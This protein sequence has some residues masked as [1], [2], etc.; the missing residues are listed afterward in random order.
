MAV[1]VYKA[2]DATEIVDDVGQE[3]FDLKSKGLV[4]AL[5][6][7]ILAHLGREI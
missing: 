4:I 7:C 1:K 2:K 6:T 3:L 5:T